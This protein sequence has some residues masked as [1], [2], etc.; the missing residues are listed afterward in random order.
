M[1]RSSQEHPMS[2]IAE[3]HPDDATGAL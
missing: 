3:I 1:V 2:R